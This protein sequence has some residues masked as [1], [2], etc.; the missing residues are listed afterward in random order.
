MHSHVRVKTR[1]Y[2]SNQS[3]RTA[4]IEHAATILSTTRL[5]NH[6]GAEIAQASEFHVRAVRMFVCTVEQG[7]ALLLWC[8]CSHKNAAPALVARLWPLRT[9]DQRGT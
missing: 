4:K 9:E 1:P 2:L 8:M 5:E 3:L 6:L 7:T